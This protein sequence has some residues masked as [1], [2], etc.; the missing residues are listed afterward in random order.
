MSKTGLITSEDNPPTSSI[1]GRSNLDMAFRLIKKHFPKEQWMNAY[2]VMLGESG[3]NSQAVGDTDTPYPSYG[4]FQIRGLPGRP[5]K[6][7]LLDPE[8]NVR[9]AAKMWKQQNWTPWTAAKN[10]G[11]VP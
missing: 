1:S 10:L 7:K 9:Y 2:K 6:K 11:L 8:F 4:M 5:S 3:G